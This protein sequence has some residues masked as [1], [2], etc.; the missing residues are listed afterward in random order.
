MSIVISRLIGGIGNQMFQYACGYSLSVLNNSKLLLDIDDLENRYS[1]HNGY[2]LDAVFNINTKIATL[3]EISSVLGWQ[4]KKIV[5]RVLLYRKCKMIRRKNFVVEKTKNY[6]PNINNIK[7]DCYLVGYWQSEKY[8]KHI[9]DI[10]KSEFVFKNELIG[11]NAKI[12]NIIFDCNSVSLHV[13]RGDYISD[14]KTN[15]VHGL[16]GV[17]YYSA[18]IKH[19]DEHI[20]CPVY[21]IFSD[22]IEWA[23][24][25]IITHSPVLYIEHN[26]KNNSFYDMQL[27]SLCKH[28]IIA[29]SSFSWWAAWLNSNADKIII[30][31]KRWYNNRAD[32]PDLLPDDWV[33]L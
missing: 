28:N 10:I 4:G 17:D 14:T 12:K 30:A 3:S 9:K 33:K 13:R 7:S 22:D 24:T 8:F 31:P 6:W 5:R 16:C 29:N 21:F 2:E 32:C 26:K 27:M 1:L 25:N 15:S 23:K 19:I 20:T 18:A 11:K